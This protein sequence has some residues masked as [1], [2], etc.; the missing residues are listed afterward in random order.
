MIPTDAKGRAMLKGRFANLTD[1]QL[2]SPAEEM[3]ELFATVFNVQRLVTGILIVIGIA[4]IGI[5]A[6][7][8]LLSYRLRAQEFENLNKIG[9]DP[10]TTKALVVFEAGFVIVA[11]LVASGL[12]VILVAAL[13]PI[14]VRV[15]LG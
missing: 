13:A 10:T 3:D 8:F 15:M 7:V 1:L 4:T 9:A 2:I 14:L 11:S 12:L 6:L 5:G